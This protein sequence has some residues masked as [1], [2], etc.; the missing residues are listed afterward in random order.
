MRTF[1]AGILFLSL[2]LSGTASWAE[3]WHLRQADLLSHGINPPAFEVIEFSPDGRTLLGYQRN[4]RDE[5]AKGLTNKVF[6]LQLRSDGKVTGVRS[7]DLRI[8]VLEQAVFSPDGKEVVLITASGAAYVVLDLSTGEVRTLM[9]HEP[10]KPGFRSYPSVMW[11]VDGRLLNTGFFYD[12]EDYGGDDAI[13]WID[14]S[15]SG[16][17]AF[18]L[19]TEVE[20]VQRGL[21]NVR[22]N[23]YTDH[24]TG[25]FCVEQ[26]GGQSFK[27]YRWKSGTEPEAFDEVVAAPGF[28][29]KRDQ[30]AYI[31][32]RSGGLYEVVIH[33]GA[34]GER[35]VVTSS[36]SPLAYLTFSEDASTLQVNEIRDGR[37]KL[38]TASSRT[39]W[40]YQPVPELPRSPVGD[41][42]LSPDGRFMSLY[43]QE[44]LRIIPLP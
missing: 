43:N 44:G 2:I 15:K 14:L 29:P 13:A 37:M 20:K 1:W 32:Q 6:V 9:A 10:R 8:P 38:F 7:F 31:A 35:R 39:G 26:E 28:M 23:A 19:A 5:V 22:I 24:Q 40:K 4:N 17:E 41:I 3:V 16:V 11:R 27:L 33:D 36:E 21:K 42:R 18:E 25:Y 12:E 34:T 30:L